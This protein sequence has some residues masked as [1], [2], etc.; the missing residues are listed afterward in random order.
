MP[1]VMGLAAIM[2]VFFSVWLVMPILDLKTDVHNLNVYHERLNERLT[3]ES[4]DL[5]QLRTNI[6]KA[7]KL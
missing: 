1:I 2:A 6:E 4:G 3:K 7:V 5:F